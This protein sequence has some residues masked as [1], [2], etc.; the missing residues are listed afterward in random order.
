[1]DTVTEASKDTAATATPGPGGWLHPGLLLTDLYHL[2]MMQAYL[3]HGMTEAASFEFFVRKL[4]ARRGFLMAAGLEQA[5][6]FLEHLRATPDEL[7][8]L[9]GNGRFGKDFLDYLERLRFTGEV[10][11][12]PEGTLVFADEPILRLTA[13]MPLAQLVETRLVNLLH[14][15]TLIASKAARMVVAAP[16]K[17]L[18]DFGLRRAHGAEAGLLAARACYIAGFA[19][20]AT[21]LAGR[22]YGVPI[23]GTMAHSFVQAHDDE[24]AAF[25]S[26][27]R[28]RPNR[29][30]LL[31]DTYDTEAGA[32]KVV[33]LAPKLAKD[34]IRVDGVRL[35]S[36][37][38][39]EHA[40]RVR[41]ILDRGGLKE[42][43]IFASGGVDEDLIIRHAETGAP[44]D[45]Y[46]IGTSLTT[47]LDAAALDCAYKLQEY[48]GLA[49]RKRSEGKATWPG[50]KQVY[51]RYAADATMAG[52]V[53]TVAGDTQGGEALIRPVMRQG[54][55]LAPAPGIEALRAH[56]AKELARLPGPLKRLE[57]GAAY[58]VEVAPA[59]RSLAEEVDAR[60][61]PEPHPSTCSG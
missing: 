50:R 56:A 24:M 45:G 23:F 29:V 35:D 43:K 33:R 21:V 46:G 15:Q 36:G 59:L 9:A 49:R 6:D 2:N 40:F 44:I 55:R 5:L 47:S 38:L 19:G 17:T 34:G 20:S 37:D 58:P 1:M 25:E 26:F 11:A 42:T 18:V 41:R 39:A 7:D 53:L 3:D 31:I 54:R 22:L 61:A 16:G 52:D 10:N 48:A 13:P 30:V 57:A 12:V 60:M 27:A 14:F 32:E 51:R 4:P 28:S 8:W